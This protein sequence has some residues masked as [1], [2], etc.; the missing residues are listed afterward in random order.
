MTLQEL[1]SEVEKALTFEPKLTAFILATT[2][3][4]DVRVQR[5]ARELT[6]EHRPKSLFTVDVWSW[7]KIWQEIYGREQ[8]LRSIGS[9][10]WP[11]IWEITKDVLSEEV[12]AARAGQRVAPGCD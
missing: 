3:P 1:N 11:R 7:E 4:A 9:I 5:R 10:Y 12:L 2:G 8:L 6:D